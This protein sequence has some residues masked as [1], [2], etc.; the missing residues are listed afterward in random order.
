[1]NQ[2][3]LN[4]EI[5]I[6]LVIIGSIILIRMGSDLIINSANTYYVYFQILCLFVLGIGFWFFR[7]G[8]LKK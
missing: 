4:T 6:G 2:K 5:A 7:K 8:R 1:M 3:K